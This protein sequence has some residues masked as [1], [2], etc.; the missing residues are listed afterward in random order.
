MNNSK[1]APTENAKS[2]A[3]A[4][5]SAVPVTAVAQP[6]PLPITVPHTY[7]DANGNQFHMVPVTMGQFLP[8]M[9]MTPASGQMNFSSATHGGRHQ[10]G[11]QGF[12]GRFSR[13]STNTQVF[14]MLIEWI[15]L[16]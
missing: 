13:G 14:L 11:V 3:I 2:E 16:H 12:R 4:N 9:Q 15:V 10:R 5:Q 8:M 1:N 7:V 6:Q